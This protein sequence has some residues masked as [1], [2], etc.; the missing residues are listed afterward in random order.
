MTPEHKVQ[1]LPVG[2]PGDVRLLRHVER[3]LQVLD[4]SVTPVQPHP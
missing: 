4:T 2:V 1:V 3:L